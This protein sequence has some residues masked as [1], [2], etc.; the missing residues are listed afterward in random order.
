MPNPRAGTVASGEDLPRL[1]EEAKAGRVELRI[2]RTANIHGPFGKAS[3]D[4][5]QLLSNL[6]MVLDVIKRAR[7]SAA[8]GVYIRR[9]VIANAMGPAINIDTLEAL[10]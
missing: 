8:K 4:N 7:P 9:L 6:Q 1:I 5:E 10:Q 3:F 2:D